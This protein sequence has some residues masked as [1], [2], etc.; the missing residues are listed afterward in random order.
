MPLISIIVP[1]Y[2]VTSYIDRYLESLLKLL[3]IPKTISQEE[4]ERLKIAYLNTF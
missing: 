3:R 1:C 2:N 4:L